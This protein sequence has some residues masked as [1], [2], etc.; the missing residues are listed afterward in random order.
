MIGVVVTF[1]YGEGFDRERVVKIATDA[2]PRFEGLAGLRS[3][4]FTVDAAN[5]RATNVYVWDSEEA[6]RAFFDGAMLERVTSLYGV[7]PT[8]EFVEIAALVENP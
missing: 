5:Q 2:A 7:Q 3:K 8:V 4:V 6:A 1:I